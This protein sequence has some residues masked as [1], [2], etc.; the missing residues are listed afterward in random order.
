MMVLVPVKRVVDDNVKIRVRGDG[1]GVEPANV[2][3]S[4]HPFE[5]IQ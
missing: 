3:T 4:M 1:S 2:K 5:E